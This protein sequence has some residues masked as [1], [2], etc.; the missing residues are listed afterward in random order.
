[1]KT[2][3]KHA[4]W[5]GLL[6]IVPQ[7]WLALGSPSD[8]SPAQLRN[9]GLLLLGNLALAL[10]LC[11]LLEVPTRRLPRRLEPVR[12]SLP[13]FFLLAPQGL[14]FAHRFVS[15]RRIGGST[16]DATFVASLVAAAILALLLV[17]LVSRVGRFPHRRILAGSAV[18][19]GLAVVFAQLIPSPARPQAPVERPNVL[20][21]VLDA[22]RPDALG[23]YG[24]S[25]D[26]SPNI[27][28]L[29]EEGMLFETAFSSSSS[30][31]PGH[32]SLLFGCGV[33]EHGAPSN[34]SDLPTGMPPSLAAR[35]GESGYRSFGICQNPLINATAGFARGFDY[36]WSWAEGGRGAAPWREALLALPVVEL[37]IKIA[38][39]E[40]ISLR[41]SLHFERREPWFGFVQLLYT[42]DPYIDADR[43]ATPARVAAI[44]TRLE[45]GRLR[46]TTDYT[47]DEIAGFIAK[48]YGSIA[49]SDR[50]LH[51]LLTKMDEETRANTVIIL[52]SDHG[53]TL[54]E[55]G[56]EGVGK[57]F[58]YHNASLRVP[59]IVHDPRKPQGR[60]VSALTG[61]DRVAD[62][63]LA[64]AQ[65]T[66]GGLPEQVAKREHVIFSAP[67]LIAVN[68]S[69]KVVLHSQK[70]DDGPTVYRWRE[71]SYDE[72][73][74]THDSLPTVIDLTESLRAAWE[75]IE[76][77]YR[78]TADEDLRP[79]KLER[80]KAL[81]Y[82]D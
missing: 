5:I 20:L 61:L 80:L 2:L 45:D 46:N 22:L 11:L 32:A 34:R 49:Y 53:E 24:N 16:R 13:L 62:I 55:H 38:D 4:G 30:S 27:D 44:R 31:V 14:L 68:D 15:A 60:R 17:L 71:D 78:P 10:A 58:G 43:W 23:C 69:L 66:E 76:P 19:G 81:G 82:V 64:F 70:L 40:P 75:K 73:P 7:L 72:S 51:E 9:A 79:E 37:L 35:M 12:P 48:Y 65:G 33:A 8:W 52:C 56:H 18:A 41:A 1:M 57:H 54:A 26:V 39:V 74:T 3:W 6:T 50:L 63:A 21:V 59:L 77:H 29:A 42:H 47:D 28:R 25:F 36:Y 67:Y